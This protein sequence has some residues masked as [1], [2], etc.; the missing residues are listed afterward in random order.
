[1][2]PPKPRSPCRRTPVAVL[3]AGLLEGVAWAQGADVDAMKLRRTPLLEEKIPSMVRRDM[4][5]FL[6]GDSLNGQIDER[7]VIEGQAELRNRSTVLRGDWLQYTLPDDTARARGNVRINREGNVYQA[8]EAELEVEAFRGYLTKPTFDLLRNGAQGDAERM[9]FLDDKHAILHNARYSTCRRDGGP[10]W[11]PDWVLKAQRI[12]I[13]NE[14]ETGVAEGATLRFMDIPILPIPEISFPLSSKRKSGFLTPII[15][16]GNVNG[17]EVSQPYYLNLA[18]NRDATVWG[19]LM[20]KRGVDLAGEFRYLEAPYQGLIWG[21]YMPWDRLRD[22]KRWGFAAVHSGTLPGG[23]GLN[24]NLNRV[25]DDNYWKDFTRVSTS[26]TTRLLPSD[27]NLTWSQGG[28]SA[29]AR[30]LYWQTL[31]DS[32][33]P[34]TPPYNRMPQLT[35]RYGGSAAAGFDYSVNADYTKFES[36]PS[37]T[38]QPNGQRA[39]VAAQVSRPWIQPGAFVTPKLMLQATNYAFDGNLSNGDARA[40]V[41]VPTVSLDS[42]LIFERDTSYFGR[43]LRQTL[44]PR[45]FYVYTPYRNQNYLPNYDTTSFDYNFTTIYQENSYA[46]NDRIAD[47]NLLTLG[48]STRLLDP[49]TGAQA[50][51]LGIANR[52]RFSAQQVTLPGQAPVPTG[53]SDI[54]VGG[55]VNW[56][57]RWSARAFIEFDAKTA[58]SVRTTV[59]GTYNPGNYRVFNAAYRLQ[60]GTSETLDVGWQWPINDLWG[61]TGL[62]LG[63]GKGQ[64]PGRWYTVGRMSY[65]LMNRQLT[66]ALLGF[67]YDAG[68]WLTRIVVSRLQ[69]ST[70]SANTNITMQLELV[71]FSRLGTS[72]LKTLR[73]HISRYQYLRD[74]TTTP[75]RFSNYD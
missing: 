58:S 56:D 1:M 36:V 75:S 28:F 16:L 30:A 45:A 54:L 12:N 21:N 53:W 18:P 17:V 50:A 27:A 15:G 14:D 44:E 49:A 61:D 68:C 38:G 22:E 35:A 70:S 19:T 57:P 31:Q 33:A 24:L 26:L 29:A 63:K 39:F 23:M 72:P 51:Q 3:V 48:L 62:E 6:S 37:L 52:L 74:Q 11:L 20:S 41:T 8:P 73:D 40:N 47:N 9:D 7:V 5:T 10:E 64:G 55:I 66:D 13:D 71:G 67:E 4:P 43:D 60:A 69:T 34:I 32:S 46:G 59:G 65:S 42:G 2:K 25:S